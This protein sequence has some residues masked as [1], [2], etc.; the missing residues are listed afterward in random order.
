MNAYD[1]FFNNN[2]VKLKLGRKRF[3][4][5]SIDEAQNMF[6]NYIQCNGFAET[7]LLKRDGE[8]TVQDELIAVFSFVGRL[9]SSNEEE[10]IWRNEQ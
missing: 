10:V 3:L 7:D 4:V 1:E 6:L 5:K 2:E 9:W 8:L